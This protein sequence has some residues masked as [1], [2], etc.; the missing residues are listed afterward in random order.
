MEKKKRVRAA[1]FN[2]EVVHLLIRLALKEKHILENKQTDSEVWKLKS[3]TWERIAAVFNASSGQTFRSVDTLKLKYDGLKK[4]LKEKVNKNKAETMKTG[5][6]HP[7]YIV[8]DG[9]EKEL[10]EVFSLSVHGL[11]STVD[12]HSVLLQTRT[13]T[14]EKDTVLKNVL[15][16]IIT[17]KEIE[18][19]DMQPLVIEVTD[20]CPG[21]P[22]EGSCHNSNFEFQPASESVVE[23][24]EDKKPKR[25]ANWA[26]KDWSPAALKSKKHPLLTP[27]RKKAE[28][29][30][31]KIEN[32]LELRE[33][34]VRQQ[35][36]H[37]IQEEKRAQEKHDREMNLLDLQ[38][39]IKENSS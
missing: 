35:I 17:E 27:R 8:I 20:N 19:Y 1:N 15:V 7:Y 14:G 11:P 3:K 37:I 18:S 31:K 32:L 2:A 12:S 5:G 39:N 25:N 33:E 29:R 21:D 9:P 24:I 10:L 4:E 26:W 28:D 16:L 34:L 6:G 38:I 23:N 30:N 13:V 36:H 22:D